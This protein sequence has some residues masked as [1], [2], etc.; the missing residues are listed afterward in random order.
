MALRALDIVRG[1]VYL[2]HE[3]R[4]PDFLDPLGLVVAVEAALLSSL[5]GAARDGLVTTDA[6]HQVLDILGMINHKAGL[7]TDAWWI[8]VT[9]QAA[10]QRFS[11]RAVF[12]VAEI[13]RDRSHPEM[14]G[15]DLNA[16]YGQWASLNDLRVATRASE[17]LAAAKLSEMVRVIE[18]NAF[19]VQLAFQ[20]TFGVTS[21]P[22]AGGVFDFR[23]RLHSVRAGDVFHHLVG[24]LKLAHCF[25]LD[26]RCVVALDALDRVV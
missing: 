13:A 26:T 9:P 24:G 6:R 21:G 15:A 14:S 18:A 8:L 5:A 1:D 17:S 16:F 10:G 23:P 22:E 25:R 7:G 3:G 11:R 12:E 19:E 20:C 2:V 4:V